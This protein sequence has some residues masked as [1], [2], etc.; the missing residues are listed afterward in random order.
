MER[1]HR[2]STRNDARP[3]VALRAT[4]ADETLRRIA[5]SKSTIIG[6]TTH[7]V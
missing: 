5:I 2:S 4:T 7:R 6:I 3:G 1:R